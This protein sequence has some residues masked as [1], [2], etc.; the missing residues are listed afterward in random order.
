MKLFRNKK[1]FLQVYFHDIKNKLGSIKF[2]LSLL[3]NPNINEEQKHSLIQSVLVTLDKTIDMLNDYLDLEKYKHEKFLKNEKI[4][5][6]QLIHEIIKELEIDIQRKNI[7]VTVES[8]QEEIIIK[9]NKKWLKK[10]LLN[11]IHNS[12]KYNH[13][14]GRVIISFA[15]E[16]KGVIL[17]IKDTGIGISEEEKKYI[18][19]KFYTTDEKEGTG[20]GLAMSKNVIES[21]GG[22]IAIDSEKGRGTKFYIYLPKVAKSIKLRRL[23]LALSG[24][25]LTIFIG[26]D[27]YY[28]FFPQQI[29]KIISDDIVLYKFENGIIAKAQINDKIKII[30]RKNLFN[31]KTKTEFFLENADISINTNHQPVKVIAGKTILKNIGTE[32]ETVKKDSV[33]TSVYKGKIKAKNQEVKK[34]QGLIVKGDKLIKTPLPNPPQNIDLYKTPEHNI[35]INWESPYKKFV[36]TLSKSKKFDKAPIL[37]YVTTKRQILL[38]DLD[39]GM[40]YFSLQSVNENLYSMPYINKLLF[41]KNFYKALQEFNNSN[42]DLAEIYVKKSLRTIKTASDKPYILYAKILIIKKDYDN[43]LKILSKAEKFSNSYE[44]NYLTAKA[45]YEKREYKKSLKYLQK[46]NYDYNTEKLSG[47]IYYK[48]NDYKKAKQ[49][50]FKVLEKNPHDKEVLKTLL[51]IFKEEKNELLIE[52][53]KNKLRNKQ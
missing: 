15:P 42:I 36:L 33:A 50:L 17:T 41:L 24:F 48:L 18:F 52:L 22:A 4:N 5:L 21:L 14:N 27:Y 32:F 2:S 31:T 13:Q 10:A 51:N 47:L 39:D 53:F 1:P 3:L 34:N 37:K 28:C 11:I 6:P 19:K 44:I 23:A 49:Y 12:I 30:A 26:L 29:Q 35:I 16:K 7:L 9:A 38:S 46:I 25:I 40:W 45:Y 43:A 20:I 8:P